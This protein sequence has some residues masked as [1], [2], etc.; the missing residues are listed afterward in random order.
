MNK[1][2]NQIDINY[3]TFR[4]VTEKDCYVLFNWFQEK[5]SLKNSINTNKKITINDHKK[6]F[7]NI[8]EN[9]EFN[10]YIFELSNTPVGQVRLE[11]NNKRKIIS[12]SVDE[13][14][15]NLGIGKKMIETILSKKELKNFLISAKVKKN[16]SA[17]IKIFKYFKFNYNI[18]GDIY[19]FEKAN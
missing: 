11:T 9:K 12:Y 15:R 8:L 10:I 3:L 13:N 19:Y 5:E 16:N 18:I 17:S 6:W 2:I 4:K 1:K 14:H 7:S